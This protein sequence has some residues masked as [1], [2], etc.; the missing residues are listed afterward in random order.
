MDLKLDDDQLRQTLDTLK[1]G[2]LQNLKL[3][4]EMLALIGAGVWGL[5]IYLTLERATNRLTVEQTKH[6]LEERISIDPTIKIRGLNPSANGLYSW[7][8]T[9]KYDI[10]ITAEKDT[11]IVIVALEWFRGSLNQGASQF[12]RANLPKTQGLVRWESRGIEVHSIPRKDVREVVAAVI[13][14]KTDRSRDVLALEDS[15][16]GVGTYEPGDI[17]R[18]ERTFYVTAKPEEFVGFNLQIG[19]DRWRAAHWWCR[20]RP[21][22]QRYYSK[23]S[24]ILAAATAPE[25]VTAPEA[26]ALESRGDSKQESSRH[27]RSRRRD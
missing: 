6:K 26:K 12:V 17:V 7:E 18:L 4:V 16:G 24:E 22:I 19:V 23:D 13:G 1:P 11:P 9:Y 2:G 25:A 15:K 14:S 5:F 27:A 8:I 20:P 10:S 3:I 21:T